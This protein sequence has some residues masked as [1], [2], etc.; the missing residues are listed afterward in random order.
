MLWKQ[1]CGDVSVVV[2]SHLSC[3]LAFDEGCMSLSV[4]WGFECRSWTAWHGGYG[5]QYRSSERRSRVM[6]EWF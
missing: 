5:P 6:F 1:V 2:A 4:L 3:Q